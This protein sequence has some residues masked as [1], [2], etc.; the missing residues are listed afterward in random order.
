MKKG[1]YFSF[2]AIIASV[3]FI[4]ALMAL[5]SYWYSVKNYLESQN[6]ELEKEAIRI[7]NL[8]LSPPYPSS[9][10]SG[11]ERLGFAMSWDDQRMDP[12]VLECSAYLDDQQWVKQRLSTGYNISI[13]VVRLSD[14]ETW[15]IGGELPQTEETLEVVK[16]HRFATLVEDDGETHL[17]K[18]ELRLYQ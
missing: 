6:D 3:I 11:M 2:D 18:I 13:K 8:L 15:N 14:G 12:D 5:L 10:C 4:M 16:M 9:Q 17:A 7:S 1:Q